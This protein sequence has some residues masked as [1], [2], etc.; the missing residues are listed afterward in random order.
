MFPSLTGRVDLTFVAPETAALETCDVVFFAT[1]HGV[2]HAQTS[3]LLRAGVRV[4][5]LSA[6][7]RLRDTTTWAQWYGQPHGAP[8]C[9]ADAVYGLVEWRRAAI[10]DARL[11]AVPGCYPTATSLPLIPLLERGLID[12]SDIIADAKSGVSGAGRKAVVGV[13]AAEVGENFQAYAVGGHRHWPEI[14]QTLD[15][16]AG[17]PVGLVF[18]PHLVPM[19]R[20]IQVSLYL[21]P[22]DFVAGEDAAAQV[23]E[24]LDKHYRDEPF[25]HVLPIGQ[26]PQTASVRGSNGVHIG[27]A[28]PPHS[29][30]VTVFSVIDNLVKGA[31]GQAVQNFNLMTGWPETTALDASALFP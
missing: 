24:V 5:D 2:A 26:S 18:Q 16:A 31:A 10:P 17:G 9:V 30:R 6:D 20:G 19:I 14:R 7:F 23:Y 1:P 27:V 25:V 3:A 21:R 4:I 15:E 28:Q 12:A 13:L 22:S 8:E 29:S 11:I